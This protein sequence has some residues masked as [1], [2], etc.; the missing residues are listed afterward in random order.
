MRHFFNLKTPDLRQCLL[1]TQN[2]NYNKGL[3]KIGYKSVL[4]K[5]R[6][7]IDF[8]NTTCAEKKEMPKP[9]CK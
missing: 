5:Y 1:L 2:A 8:A 6:D 9:K 3:G 4:D 7:H